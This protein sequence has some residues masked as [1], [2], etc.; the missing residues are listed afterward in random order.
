MVRTTHVAL[1]VVV[2]FA[3]SVPAYADKHTIVQ[4]AKTF[5]TTEITVK[6]GDELVFQNSDDITHNI[7][8]NSAGNAFNL[9]TQAPGTA[10]GHVFQ[11]EGVA[12]IRCAFH[13]KMKLTVTVKK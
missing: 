4:K 2:G 7:F 6:P 13:P 11:S 10:A 8:T 12:E 9:K 5:S 3:L 1:T